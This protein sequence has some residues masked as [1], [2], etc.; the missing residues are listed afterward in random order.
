[1][2]DQTDW[3][4]RA[5]YGMLIHDIAPGRTRTCNLRF[6]R[7]S[8]CPI[9]LRAPDARRRTEPRRANFYYPIWQHKCNQQSRADLRGHGEIV[10]PVDLTRRTPEHQPVR[11]RRCDDR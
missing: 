7:P 2:P 8:L 4:T 11:H 6:R 9:A 10:R 3:F 1:M 5:R